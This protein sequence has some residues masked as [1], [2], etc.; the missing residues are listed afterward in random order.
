M[1]KNNK[2]KMNSDLGSRCT[3]YPKSGFGLGFI[4]VIKIYSEFEFFYTPV[5][6]QPGPN[7]PDSSGSRSGPDYFAISM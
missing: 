7:Y 1:I 3:G 4:P 6:V 2:R 5:R